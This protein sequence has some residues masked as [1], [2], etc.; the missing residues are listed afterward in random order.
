MFKY[1]KLGTSKYISDI[2]VI[3]VIAI[4]TNKVNIAFFISIKI[5]PL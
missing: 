5:P 4:D 3:I 2:F 1:T